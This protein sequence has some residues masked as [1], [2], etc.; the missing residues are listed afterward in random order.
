MENGNMTIDVAI[1]GGGAAGMTAAMYAS[2]AGLKAVVFEG[3]TA[4]GQIGNIK[5]LDN[6]PGFPEGIDGFE[7]AWACKQQAERFGAQIVNER[8]VAIDLES[9]PKRL[10]TDAGLYE[11]RTV[12]IATGARNRK[13]GVAGEDDLRGRGISYCATCDGGFFRGRHVVVYGGSSIALEDALYLSRICEKVTLIHR[14]AALDATAVLVDAAREAGNIEIRLRCSIKELHE[15]DGRLAG[16]TVKDIAVGTTERLDC[17]AVFVAIGN[18]PNSD[19][20]AGQ[21]ELQGEYIVAGE[22]CE[23]N[24]PGV[25]A[26]GDVRTKR[27]RQVVTA[28]ADGAIAAENA[29]A[30]IATGKA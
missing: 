13:M 30:L 21:V 7:F 28:A 26:A 5:T 8:V 9:S 4:G 2:R 29:A 18:V 23:T 17:A 14:K 20:F 15:A 3:M 19:L 11:A 16:I 24:I 1:L 6:Y 22:E 25:Y 27:L 12:I 10:T